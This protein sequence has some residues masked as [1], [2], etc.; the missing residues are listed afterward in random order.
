MPSECSTKGDA[1]QRR[2]AARFAAAAL[3]LGGIA[4][5]AVTGIS[6]SE[7]AASLNAVGYKTPAGLRVYGE[8]GPEKVP[9]ELGPAL[10][11]PNEGLTGGTIDGIA[12]NAHEELAYHHH[13][14][15]VMFVDGHPYSLPYGVGMVSP[16]VV[17]NTPVG[18]FALG[19]QTCL[20]WTHVHAQDGIVHIESPVATN[21]TLGQV[22]DVWH[23]AL[24]TGQLG[25]YAGKVTATVTGR[26]WRT[27]PSSIPL[28]EH[29]QIVL[30]VGGP[31]ITPPP[32]NWS[33]TGL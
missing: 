19:S 8:L 29:A 2:R 27:A 3:S 28:T 4:I 22:M 1:R 21:F 16:I 18:A 23:V 32:I 24:S 11:P 7:S 12:C 10:A 31:V 5:A 26:K 6:T 20:Y 25:P 15:V 9:L 30:N 13:V 33:G 17:R 14:H